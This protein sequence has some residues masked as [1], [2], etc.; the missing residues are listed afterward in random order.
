MTQN[1]PSDNTVRLGFAQTLS[2]FLYDED[3]HKSIQGE[4]LFFF[5]PCGLSHPSTQYISQGQTV[6]Y[7]TFREREHGY[8]RV[9]VHLRLPTWVNLS[10]WFKQHWQGPQ[11]RHTHIYTH[12][13]L[14]AGLSLDVQLWAGEENSTPTLKKLIS[15]TSHTPAPSYNTESNQP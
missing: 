4:G 15:H 13:H 9:C 6:Y 11:H 3:M 2:I 12:C 5:V 14:N 7:S 1:N 8:V 10:H